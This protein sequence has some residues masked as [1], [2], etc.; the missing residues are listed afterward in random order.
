M[1]ERLLSAMGEVMV[2]PLQFKGTMIYEI[3]IVSPACRGVRRNEPNDVG[4]GRGSLLPLGTIELCSVYS[5]KCPLL[6]LN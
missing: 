3:S 6:V 2:R 4:C 1:R 5:T